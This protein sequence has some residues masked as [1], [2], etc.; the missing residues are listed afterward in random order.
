MTIL[1]YVD[2]VILASN[3]LQH[4]EDV[5]HFLS[6]QFNLKNLGQLKYFLSI[7]V[8][9]SLKRI[10]LSQRKYALEILEDARFLGA[11]PAKLPM[12]QNLVLTQSDGD[13]LNDPSSYR[14]LVGRLIY[15]TITRPDLV[16]V[17]HV[18]SQ[19]MDKPCISHL[20]VAHRALK[21]L[22]HTSG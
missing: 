17:V 19:F 1:V 15:M 21:Y 8:A 11:K 10:C 2:D 18:L 6:K 22:K 4:N 13:L 12:E 14:H 7:K 5:K 20:K 3:N 16:Y 9:R